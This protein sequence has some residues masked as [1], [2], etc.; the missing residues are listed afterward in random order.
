MPVFRK[1]RSYL[2]KVK[3]K[4][5]C[6]VYSPREYYSW[7]QTS[8]LVKLGF[9][10]V[11]ESKL[12]FEQ[13]DVFQRQTAIYILQVPD[14][15]NIIHHLLMLI[16]W[17][18]ALGALALTLH[19]FVDQILTLQDCITHLSKKQVIHKLTRFMTD[20][21]VCRFVTCWMVRHQI[22]KQLHLAQ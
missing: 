4:F 18:T 9:W 3:T 7:S 10:E 6:A 14:I 11:S 20:S 16:K 2:C 5:L 19:C 12:R 21:S 22:L 13:K 1:S 8:V 17:V 15:L